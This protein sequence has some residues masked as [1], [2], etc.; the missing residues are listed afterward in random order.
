MMMPLLPLIKGKKAKAK[1]TQI[2]HERS[3]IFEPY[4]FYIYAGTPN[5]GLIDPDR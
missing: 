4:R 1:E 3:R 5:I 2:I